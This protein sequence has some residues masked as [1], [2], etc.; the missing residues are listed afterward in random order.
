M[1]ATHTDFRFQDVCNIIL[2]IYTQQIL[3]SLPVEWFWPLISG[4]GS[5]GVSECLWSL[6]F[7]RFLV[8]ELVFWDKDM[9]RKTWTQIDY[10][11]KTT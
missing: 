11:L 1:W 8:I 3:L 5:Y 4:Q 7:L 9:Y 6:S 2:L 10:F